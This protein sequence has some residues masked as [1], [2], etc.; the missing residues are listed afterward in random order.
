LLDLT[1][2]VVAVAAEDVG[3]TG[4]AAI[5]SVV[6]GPVAAV[7]TTAVVAVGVLLTASSVATTLQQ[8][9]V[10]VESCSVESHAVVDDSL[11]THS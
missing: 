11:S 9:V 6:T 7:D 5:E 4:Y 8:H 3:T 2:P 1:S 10:P